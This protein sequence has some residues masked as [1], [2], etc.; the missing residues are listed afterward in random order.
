MFDTNACE[1]RIGVTF[2]DK[3]ILEQA[4]T[5]RSYLN[6]NKDTGR[7]HNERLEFLG[8]AVLE[9]VITHFLYEKYPDKNEGELT[10]YRSALVKTETLS[11]VSESLGFNDFLLL[12]RGEAKDTGR[13]R[14]YIL[15]NTFESVVGAIY[16]D[17]GYDTAKQFIYDHIT[18]LIDAI[19]KEGTWIDAKSRFQEKSQEVVGTTPS[20]RTVKEEGPDHDKH[21]TV[22]VFL[23]KE[24]VAE[25]SGKSKQDAEQAA[26]KAAM[27]AKGWEY[28]RL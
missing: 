18:N 9:L 28:D 27:D 21:F 25:G 5:H 13:A 6:E 12:S 8:D 16:L 26:A 19:L 24:K 17:Q 11:S 10:A 3:S 4:F 23:G 20:Y 1:E 2:K 7:E 15:A 14:Q 22:G